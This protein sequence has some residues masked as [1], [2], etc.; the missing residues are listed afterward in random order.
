MD[1]LLSIKIT[2]TLLYEEQVLYTNDKKTK[3]KNNKFFIQMKTK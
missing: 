3:Q 2:V 1:L